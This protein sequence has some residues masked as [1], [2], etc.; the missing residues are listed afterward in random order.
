MLQGHRD[1]I[2]PSVVKL[3]H[4][5]GVSVVWTYVSQPVKKKRIDNI[6]K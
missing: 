1:F 4:G 3:S 2:Y 5:G 6:K